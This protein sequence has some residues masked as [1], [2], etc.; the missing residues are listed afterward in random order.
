MP[1]GQR[2]TRRT[3]HIGAG[4][5]QPDV[6]VNLTLGQA[7]AFRDYRLAIAIVGASAGLEV[8]QFACDV[9][10]VNASS[11]FILDLVQAAF[12]AAIAQSLPLR[13]V[14]GFNWC[15]PELWIVAHRTHLTSSASTSLGAPS[16][17]SVFGWSAGMIASGLPSGPIRYGVWL[18]LIK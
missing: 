13:A 11:I 2:F 6:I 14:E 10:R 1:I 15:L 18:W 12:A 17:T 7:K 9:R 8:K 4:Y 3:Q 16:L 5:R